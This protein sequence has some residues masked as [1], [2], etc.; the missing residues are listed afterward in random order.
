M[1]SYPYD[2]SRL[3]RLSIDSFVMPHKSLLD[4]DTTLQSGQVFRWEWDSGW[5]WGVINRAA[6]AI[7]PT[8]DG[9]FV[10]ST[11]NSG[12]A[13]S[14][15]SD[16]LRL[17]DDLD[18]IYREVARDVYLERAVARYRG[19]RL[20]RQDPWEC[21]VSFVCSQVS[22]IPKIAKNLRSLVEKYG[23]PVQ[24]DAKTLYIVPSPNV[25]ARIGVDAVRELGWGFRA[26]YLVEIAERL[27]ESNLDLMSL[28]SVSYNEAKSVLLKFKGVGE[29]VADCVLVFSLDKLE[30]FPIDRWVWRAMEEW[31]G[32]NAKSR[33]PDVV[34]WAQSKW[35]NNSAYVQQYLFHYRRMLG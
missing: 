11:L 28:R 26:K 14:A 12:E 10:R 18:Q 29:K 15:L 20:L 2:D 31:Y 19:M 21:L 4:L 9:L 3:K 22:N 35:G 27:V 30:A 7:R 1:P 24:L 32:Q 6:F 17:G 16:F 25:I 5:W 33:Y 13:I 8:E 34:A 23:E